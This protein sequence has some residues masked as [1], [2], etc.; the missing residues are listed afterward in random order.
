M[1]VLRTLNDFVVRTGST[2]S[3]T[4]IV[5]IVLVR[6]ED[7]FLGQV[8][9]NIGDF[10]DRIIVADNRSTDRTAVV[11]AEAQK[12]IQAIEY[13]LINHPSQSHELIKG[14]AGSRTWVFAVDGD[15]LYDPFGLK[16]FR[17]VLLSGRLDDHW[18]ILGNVLNC[19]SLD[20]ERMIARGYLAPPC[21]SMV[22]LYNFQAIEAWDGP[23]P[24]RLHGGTIRFNPG[25]HK[26]M[27]C[28]W[29]EENDWDH[30]L[31]RCL[32]VCFLPRSSRDQL[33]EGMPNARW[34]ISERNSLPWW[35]RPFAILQRQFGRNA[36]SEYKLEKY[37]RGSFVA[38]DVAHFIMVAE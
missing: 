4:Q 6:N 38:K 17:E 35:R 1:G 29:H 31:L 21:R 13:H 32:H 20:K 34:N 28:N 26:G 23:C 27:R 19:I 22:K 8:L 18:Q 3:D 16:Q 37:M 2:R 12:G 36:V 7:L 15:E 24:E 30:S 33:R 9:R 14:L 10:C 25:F 11:V 5:G